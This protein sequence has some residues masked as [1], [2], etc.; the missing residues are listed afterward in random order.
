MIEELAKMAVEE[1]S[2][3][4]MEKPMFE[5]SNRGAGMELPQLDDPRGI[6]VSEGDFYPDSDRDISEGPQWDEA[7]LEDLDKPSEL[8]TPESPVVYENE[9][10]EDG[11]E[12]P[13]GKDNN[14]NSK[15][16]DDNSEKGNDSGEKKG[17]TDEEKQ[18]IKEKTGWSDEI[19]D[20]IGSMEEAQIYM[21]VGLQEVEIDGKKC[22]IRDDID[23]DQVDEDGISN[24]E[25]MER[26][27]PPLTKDGQEVELHHIGQKPGSPLAELTTQE[28][29]GVGNDTVL[30]DKNKESEIDR[31]EFAKERAIG[32]LERKKEEH[33]MSNIIDVVNNLPELISTGAADSASIEYA[34]KELGLKFANEYKEYLGE[35]GSVLADDVE[36]TGISKSK[37]RDVVTV[38]KREWSLNSQ[39]EHNMYVVE[40][41]AIE[42]IIIWQDENGTIY[43]TSPNKSAKKV[44][45]SLTDYII[46]QL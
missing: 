44:A 31:N 45:N 9:N 12:S 46:C 41:L 36:I 37:S 21:D 6:E 33:K 2:K 16:S 8:G 39:A 29:R 10:P 19:I 35:F 17:L 27:R 23:M 14:E 34:E 22:L 11:G 7:S 25:R 1:S 28:H 30:H 4:N 42:G 32:S 26:G 5:D 38:T 24:R 18:E 40:N 13:E 43:E 20:A 15:D 3:G